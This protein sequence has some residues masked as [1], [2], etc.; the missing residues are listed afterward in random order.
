MDSGACIL[1]SKKLNLH[2]LRTWRIPLRTPRMMKSGVN[3]RLLSRDNF[4]SLLMMGVR[5]CFFAETM[6]T[7]IHPVD[8][9]SKLQP[10]QLR[11]HSV[12]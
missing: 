1:G 11:L 6:M 7:R 12:L 8:Y 4:L 9:L 10:S 2:L 5:L 3:Q